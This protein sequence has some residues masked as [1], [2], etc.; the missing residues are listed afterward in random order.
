MPLIETFQKFALSN[1]PKNKLIMRNYVS[2]SDEELINLYAA[3]NNHAIETL[4]YRHKDKVYSCIYNLVKD[5]DNADDIFQDV[6]IKVIDKLKS[7]CYRHEDKFLNWI[8]RISYNLCMDKFRS[9]RHSFKFIDITD[10]ESDNITCI[11]DLYPETEI[12]KD[13]K[14][15]KIRK[16]ID[17]LPTE[18][19]EIVIMRHY[20][21]LSFKEISKIV[22]CTLNTALGRMRYGLINLRKMI[23][24]YDLATSL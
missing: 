23:E 17:R 14:I 18:Q 24:E 16:M 7:G 8:M 12:E 2:L 4:I 15:N 9:K 11:T 20:A 5:R 19:R 6:F 13:Q 1:H 21:D 3:G 10:E 22:G